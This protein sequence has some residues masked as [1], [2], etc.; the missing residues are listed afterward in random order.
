MLELLKCIGE[1]ETAIKY[2]EYYEDMNSSVNKNGWDGEW[3]IRYF[4][5]IGNPIGS[6]NN[7][8]GQ[9]YVNAQSWAVISGFAGL[10][11]AEIALKSVNKI[12]NT[13]K[14]IK[15]SSPGYDGYLP[16]K[17]GITTYP[18]G[19]K[20]NG[21]IFLHSN[22]WAIIAEAIMGNGNQAFEYYNQINP[23]Y[24]NS[25]I[26]EYE[27]EPYCYCQNILGNEHPR[28]GMARNS[29][30][31]G[32]SSWAYQAAIKFILGVQPTYLGIR[33]DPCIPREWEGFQVEKKF[34]NATYE[35][36]VTNPQGINKGIKSIIVDGYRIK[37]NVLPVFGDEMTHVVLVTMGR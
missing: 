29:W 2:K 26:D 35:I 24:K 14:G 32:T 7:D 23:V 19:A 30:L 17:G 6:R 18:P 21:G 4:D 5:Y 10:D 20:E 33:I 27:C 11:R 25:L 8:K 36:R 12:L 16:E 15:L 3:Y 22:P 9:I 1:E 34:R 37:G 28:F 13:K 31:S